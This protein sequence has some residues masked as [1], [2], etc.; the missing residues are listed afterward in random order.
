MIGKSFG[1]AAFGLAEISGASIIKT[2]K[3]ESPEHLD[4]KRFENLHSD[5]ST[6]EF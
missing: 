2:L 3:M 6:I 4:G 1:L 5:I